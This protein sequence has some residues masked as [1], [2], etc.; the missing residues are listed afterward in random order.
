MERWLMRRRL[1]LSIL[2]VAFVAAGIVV[3]GVGP[4]RVADAAPGGA[5]ATVASMNTSRDFFALARLN[6]GRV[7]ASGGY[8]LPEGT[9]SAINLKSAEL[10]DPAADTWTPVGSMSAVRQLHTAV[11]LKNG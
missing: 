10:Y 7:L 11:T 4:N 9:T 1:F 6:D 3:P 8:T 5:W 2:S